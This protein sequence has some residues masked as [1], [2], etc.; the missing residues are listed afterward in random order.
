MIQTS[1][2]SIVHKLVGFGLTLW[3]HTC[4]KLSIKMSRIYCVDNL[5]VSI[6]QCAQIGWLQS[7]KEHT[8]HCSRSVVQPDTVSRCQTNWLVVLA[9]PWVCPIRTS[10]HMPQACTYAHI[11]YV[12]TD[13]HTYVHV[14]M[15]G[16]CKYA[17]LHIYV[18]AVQVGA[19]LF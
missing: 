3:L 10:V 18:Y 13:T 7:N 1:N 12:H 16:G 8:R 19:V 4:S 9:L 14:C 6:K 5:V 15:V 17:Y 11:Q 2:Y